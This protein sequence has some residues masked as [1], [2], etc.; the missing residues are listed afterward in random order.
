MQKKYRTYL[1]VLMSSL[2]M[3]LAIIVGSAVVIDPYALYREHEEYVGLNKFARLIKPQ[4]AVSAEPEV[5]ISGSSRAE[6]FFDTESLQ[7][8]MGKPVFNIALSGAN[9]YEVRRNIEHVAAVAPIDTII[10]GL[11]F[12]MFKADRDVQPGFVEDRLAIGPT[13]AANPFYWA[14]DLAATLASRDALNEMRRS[15]KYRNRDTSCEYRWDRSGGVVPSQDECKLKEAAGQQNLFRAGLDVYLSHAVSVYGAF[16][17]DTRPLPSN[18]MEN[19]DRLIMLAAEDRELI[20]YISPV[21]ALHLAVYENWNVWEAF[22]NWKTLLALKVA[23][24]KENGISVELRDFAFVSDLTARSVFERDAGTDIEFYDT[25]HLRLTQRVRVQ[26]EL[27]G[28]GQPNNSIG[29]LLTPESLEGHLSETRIRLAD[30]ME[31]HPADMAV[32]DEMV[33]AA[34]AQN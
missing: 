32:F 10:V 25:N 20:L 1:I 18:S 28:R 34:A 31:S 22:E 21:H 12:F 11:D 9:I 15:V 3:V 26:E 6:Y 16:E 5:V 19:I 7:E 17:L 24:A 13:G 27:L 4:W 29:V 2:C 30:W 23:E 14:S 8:Q 33:R